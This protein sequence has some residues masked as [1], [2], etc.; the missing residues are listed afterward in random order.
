MNKITLKQKQIM[1]NRLFLPAVVLT[2]LVVS[3]AGYFLVLNGKY[4]VLT[5]AKSVD[6]PAADQRL[7]S[8]QRELDAFKAGQLP[9]SAFTAEEQRLLTQVLP[10]S[11]DI[12]SL[13][14]QL[15]NLAKAN[16]FV[17]TSVTLGNGNGN[18][19][20]VATST[21]NTAKSA[22]VTVNFSGG[23][24]YDFQNLLKA[25]ESSVMIF[26]VKSVTFAGDAGDIAL[27][28]VT[29]YYPDQVKN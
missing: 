9:G 3:V 1:L 21:K 25:L 7:Q 18:G 13:T 6:L 8:L 17:M 22:A 14:I 11:V 26:D 19:A 2:L 28:M 15:S 16:N 27:E 12:S 24:Y 29:Y 20:T 10:S 23:T 5:N 4:Q